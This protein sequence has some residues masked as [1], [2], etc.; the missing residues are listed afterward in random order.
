[1]C[2]S[3][4]TAAVLPHILPKLVHPPLTAFNA[5]ALGALAEVAGPG[6]NVHL[7]TLLPPLIFAMGGEDEVMTI[8]LSLHPIFLCVCLS[9]TRLVIL[10]HGF[11][12]TWKLDPLLCLWF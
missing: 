10:E 8:T 7:S 5:H 4:R 6:L 3:V 12:W 2:S 11:S 1:M 9:V